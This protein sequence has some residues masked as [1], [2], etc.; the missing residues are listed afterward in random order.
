MPEALLGPPPGITRE[1]LGVT[2]EEG[3]VPPP[4]DAAIVTDRLCADADRFLIRHGEVAL[5]VERG[6]R[7]VIE[8]PDRE[9]RLSYDYLAYSTA[10]RVAMWQ[11]RRFSLHATLVVSPEGEAVAITGHSMVGKSTTTIELLRRGWTFGC[12]DLLEVDIRDGT[13]WAV[14]RSR[15][16]HLSDQVAQSL[17]V[18]PS[19]GRRLPW[20]GKRAYAIEGFP[21]PLPLERVVHLRVADG[22]EVTQE[23]L[24]GLDALAL[25]AHHSD[26]LGVC[27]LP[28]CRADYLEWSVQT[29]AG[30]I[31]Q[32]VSRPLEGD[33]VRQVADALSRD[34]SERPETL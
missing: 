27:N 31:M 13:P 26:P 8:S 25:L 10:P 20:Q 23:V 18:D 21:T 15:P 1:V 7:F 5:Y 28:E 9:T 29:R 17:G 12:D 3:P 34:E 32:T 2:I 33:S 30:V 19:V 16:V 6:N 11:T 14:P 24:V 22:Q 4:W